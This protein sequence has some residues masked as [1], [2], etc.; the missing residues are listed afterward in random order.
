[1]WRKFLG[2]LLLEED[3]VSNGNCVGLYIPVIV[4]VHLHLV[5]SLLVCDPGPDYVSMAGSGL[6]S[7]R[8]VFTLRPNS[9]YAG[10]APVVG[11]G[12][13]LKLLRCLLRSMCGSLC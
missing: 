12:V 7:S 8:I 11:C 3:P 2:G 9:S 13:A 1:M 10:L 4:I 6:E 5:L